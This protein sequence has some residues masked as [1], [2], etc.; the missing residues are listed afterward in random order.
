MP[1][2]LPNIEQDDNER[3]ALVDSS[4]DCNQPYE[5]IKELQPHEQGC[6]QHARVCF[7]TLNWMTPKKMH[8]LI[9]QRLQSSL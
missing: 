5:D 3:E 7:Q 9:Q 2:M 8:R 6:V 4:R 1:H